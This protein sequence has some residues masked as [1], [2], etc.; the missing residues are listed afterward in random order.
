MQNDQTALQGLEN[1]LLKLGQKTLSTLRLACN[2][3]WCLRRPITAIL[4][5]ELIWSMDQIEEY[6]DDLL[7]LCGSSESACGHRMGFQ[8]TIVQ[9]LVL[10]LSVLWYGV[11]VRASTT[12]AL[13][14][15][16]LHHV[17]SVDHIRL[18][19]TL[20]GSIPLFMLSY[21]LLHSA[22]H[23][24]SAS[25]SVALIGLFAL[26]VLIM[27]ITRQSRRSIRTSVA[28]AIF[29]AIAVATI[30]P[31]DARL[32]QWNWM[33]GYVV[34][35][36]TIFGAIR[37]AGR[38]KGRMLFALVSLLVLATSIMLQVN[39]VSLSVAPALRV[40]ILP[41]VFFFPCLL[42]WLPW[43]W[44]VFQG[45]QLERDNREF[46]ASY[47]RSV[48]RKFAGFS[49]A[50]VTL[51]SIGI[52]TTCILFAVTNYPHMPQT[53]AA[54]V[55]TPAAL[56]LVLAATGNAY[57]LASALLGRAICV[58]CVAAA[59]LSLYVQGIP[60]APITTAERGFHFGDCTDPNAVCPMEKRIWNRYQQ[61][62]HFPGRGDDT[63]IILVAA[64]GGGSRAAA[65]TA[66]VLAAVDAATCGAFGDHVFAISSVSGGALGSALY[67]ASRRDLADPAQRERCRLSSPDSRGYPLAI[68]LIA[69]TTGDHLSPV[70]LRAV[71]H[72]L[73]NGTSNSSRPNN[74]P[75]WTDFSSRAA[76]L[77]MSW[78]AAYNKLLKTHGKPANGGAL[79]GQEL[80][81][82]NAQPFLISN[83][84]SVQDGH[85]VLLS[86][87]LLCPRDGWCAQRASLLTDATDSARFPL[88][89]PPRARNA[90][91]WNPW[92]HEM[93][94]SE[95]SI[96]DGGYFDNS[97][98]QTLLDIISALE[99]NK[100]SASRLFVVLISSDPDEGSNSK[101]VPDYAA[102]SWLVQLA[103]PLRS[104]IGV[105]E[106][107]TS[108]ALNELA[109][110]LQDCHVI[111][112][113]MGTKSLNPLPPESDSRLHQDTAMD[114]VRGLSP[115]EDDMARLERAPA[116]G[117]SLSPRSANQLWRL[118]YGQGNAYAYG[119]F[120]YPNELLLAT[121]LKY[122][123][124][125]GNENLQKLLAKSECAEK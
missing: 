99:K 89:S 7:Y 9:M 13:T 105:R 85:R 34:A 108:I 111:H 12:R 104:I 52:I 2:F 4:L 53:V 55:I 84:T 23:G 24:G 21:R 91:H 64:A 6:F 1:K 42:L 106:G 16:N 31:F 113:S 68:E 83:A 43:S 69:A 56:V 120:K 57:E 74:S 18:V 3:A 97:G 44:P 86:Y 37:F 10:T 61:W 60:P 35:L 114:A 95:R 122:P 75:D 8:G 118:A 66:S 81:E 51:N 117:W 33:L 5:L 110:N 107:R 38:R 90:F 47:R 22:G 36:V 17:L 72:D 71:G 76:P 103:A 65:H 46:L 45:R 32:S 67:A 96:V 101:T 121:R 116:L 100:I 119:N 70:V 124:G 109:Q 88:V 62:A 123:N 80:L 40:F 98:G 30:G 87:P 59:G 102:S 20:F 39:Y 63:P 29:T 11:S 79:L 25:V 48:R 125:A 112:W 54:W 27:A 58:C 41:L 15:R 14:A 78:I 19:A 115:R 82:D 92:L 50:T 26:V 73:L 28:W 49:A 77:Q 94:A 93:T